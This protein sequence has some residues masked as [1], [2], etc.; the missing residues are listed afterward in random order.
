[1]P[2]AL[3]LAQTLFAEGFE[4]PF[5]SDIRLALGDFFRVGDFLVE[6]IFLRER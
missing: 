6:N 3:F 1:M 4:Q 2:V 5:G